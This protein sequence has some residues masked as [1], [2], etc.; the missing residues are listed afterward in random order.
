M[1]F[2]F[3]HSNSQR[4]EIFALRANH[5]PVGC[6][7]RFQGVNMP[8]HKDTCFSFAL[9][10][11]VQT[12]EGFLYLL[13]AETRIPELTAAGFPP[14]LRDVF[15]R[16]QFDARQR[17][18]AAQFP[19][20]ADSIITS[21]ESPIGRQLVQRNQQEILLI[22]IALRNGFRNAGVG[23]ALLQALCDEARQTGRSVGLHV[24]KDNPAQRLYQRLGFA[25]NGDAG[26]YWRMSWPN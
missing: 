19:R 22:D 9:R 18:Y 25:V 20:A 15:L 7:A 26:A 17:H 10:P 21:A 24:A 12:D 8:N 16:Q 13:Y 5:L 6:Q 3:Y 2:T 4:T 23:T 11:T 1:Q 14:T